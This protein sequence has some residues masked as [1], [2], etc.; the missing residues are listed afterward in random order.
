MRVDAVKGNA[1]VLQFAL[2]CRARFQQPRQLIDDHDRRL[3][4]G[5]HGG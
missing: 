3:V 1:D 2:K 5:Q 4:A